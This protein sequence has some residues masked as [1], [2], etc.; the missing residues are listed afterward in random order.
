MLSYAFR[1]LRGTGTDR[2]GSEDFANIHDL[3]AAIL[4]RGVNLQIKR[5]LHRDYTVE[6]EA[7]AGVRGRISVVETIKRQTQPK[8]LLVCSFDEFT[9]NSPLNQA[10]KSVMRLLIRH[11]AVERKHK[12]ELQRILSFF[13]EVSNIEPHAIQWNA[14]NYHRNNASYQMLMEICRLTVKG[15]LMT[16]ESG[17]L[18][19]RSFL[20][21]E[22]MYQ[23]YERFVREYFRREHR[24]VYSNER[25]ISWHVDPHVDRT[26]L[27]SMQCDLML[28]KDNKTILLDTKWYSKT[29]A[30]YYGK[31]TYHSANL[32]QIYSYVNNYAKGESG[33]TKG[34]LLYAKTDDAITPDSPDFSI[35]GNVISVKTLDLDCDWSEITA[36]LSSLCEWLS[37]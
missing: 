33:R 26:R 24:E 11:G 31:Q 22:R 15:L 10:L 27:P 14:M 23:V 16:D 19:L 5:G 28:K 9:T 3:F 37:S 17:K 7:I 34:I 30:T 32:Y 6:E 2:L 12:E 1:A 18:K 29:M 21:D 20:P 25:G 13:V 8:G 35:G 36:Q 4:I